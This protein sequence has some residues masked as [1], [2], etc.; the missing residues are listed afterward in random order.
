MVESADGFSAPALDN[1]ILR[2]RLV[3]G[4]GAGNA[5]RGSLSKCAIKYREFLTRY[6]AGED[7]DTVETAKQDLER[8]IHLYKVEMK[9]VALS[10]QASN[11]DTERVDAQITDV[12]AEIESMQAEIEALR[13]EHPEAK[14]VRRNIEEYEALAKMA[15]TRPSRRILEERTAK[16][17]KE[18]E[19]FEISTLKNREEK[20]IREKQFQLFIQSLFDLKESLAEDVE[21]KELQDKQDEE[22]DEGEVKSMDTT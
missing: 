19:G 5:A 15:S 21:K 9:R 8:E 17:K 6:L 13:K 20:S 3:Q 14:Q 12:Q 11:T 10:L 16:V 7:A 2:Q 22:E 4:V 1:V 18:L